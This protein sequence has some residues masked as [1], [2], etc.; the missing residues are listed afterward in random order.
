MD[1]VICNDCKFVQLRHTVDSS[2][3]YKEYWYRSGTNQTMRDHLRSVVEQA[4]SVRPLKAGDAVI[5]IGCNDGTLLKAYTIPG[6]RRIGVDP[7]D[8][9]KAIDD[10]SIAVVNNFFTAKNVEAQLGGKKARIITSISMFYD[11]DRPH[12]FLV[13]IVKCLTEDGLWVVE[14]NYTGNM[15]KALGYDMIGHEHLAY[16]TLRTFERLIQKHGLYINDVNF[17]AINGGSVRFICGFKKQETPLVAATREQELQDGLEEVETYLAFGRRI[18]EFKQKLIKTLKDIHAQGKK[19]SVYG[20]S[21]RGNMILQHCGLTRELLFA[22]ADRNPGKWG[23]ETP[24]S[25]IPIR[26]E[27]EVRKAN[28]EYMLVLPCY[29]LPEFI[30]REKD[31]L[32]NGG[33]FIAP[34]PKLRLITWKKGEPAHTEQLL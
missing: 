1:L 13:D 24:G 7:S 31:Y 5:D 34:L 21:T 16:Y 20:A 29:F 30:Q 33:I 26:S 11:L 10:P 8:A 9:V 22:A 14:M 28:P 32:Q 27:E 25:R 17:S 12:D 23:L 18:E 15:I 6:L 2:L 4:L 19:V 3:M